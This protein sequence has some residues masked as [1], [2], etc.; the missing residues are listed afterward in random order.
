MHQNTLPVPDR[1]GT[2]MRCPIPVLQFNIDGA[3]PL[4]GFPLDRSGPM[5]PGP[6]KTTDKPVSKPVDGAG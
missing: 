3:C 6:G 2:V 4:T 5:H 1:Q